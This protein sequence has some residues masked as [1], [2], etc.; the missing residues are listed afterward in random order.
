M[1]ERSWSGGDCR[2]NPAISTVGLTHKEINMEQPDTTAETLKENNNYTRKSLIENAFSWHNAT[3]ESRKKMNQVRTKLKKL[4]TEL[5][6]LCPESREKSLAMTH[7][8]EVMFWA[9]SSIVKRDPI[10]E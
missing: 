7:L 8:E 6:E 5:D 9:N 10:A 3:E 2:S 1:L 4:A